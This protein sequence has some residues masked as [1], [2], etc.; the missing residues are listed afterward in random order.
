[1]IAARVSIDLDHIQ[2]IETF[3]LLPPDM[4]PGVTNETYELHTRVR[5]VRAGSDRQY[6]Q[7]RRMGDELVLLR[8]IIQCD[9]LS[10]IEA[11]SRGQGHFQRQPRIG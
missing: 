1:M 4:L 5:I 10:G 6:P 9:Y 8:L 7:S 11:F 3:V 2:D